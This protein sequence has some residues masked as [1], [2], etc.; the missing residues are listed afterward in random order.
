MILHLEFAHVVTRASVWFEWSRHLAV[1]CCVI[2]TWCK[3][4]GD[5]AYTL[6]RG[7][8]VSVYADGVGVSP[9]FRRWGSTHTYR[10]IHTA[11]AHLEETACMKWSVAGVDKLM[12][13]GS[14]GHT[15]GIHGTPNLTEIHISLRGGG[16]LKS[17][18]YLSLSSPGPE[19]SD[20]TQTNCNSWILRTL[21]QQCCV[22]K[23][24]SHTAQTH[25][26]DSSYRA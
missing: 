9:G 7:Q 6:H 3:L 24:L 4:R 23:R 2:S 19:T 14:S 26:L 1:M 20:Q 18:T 13:A 5:V 12:G 8:E 25:N 11:P 22:H 17:S 10:D 21:M 16:A 15:A